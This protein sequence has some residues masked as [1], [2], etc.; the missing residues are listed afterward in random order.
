MTSKTPR[1]IEEKIEMWSKGCN[2]N[3]DFP[4]GLRYCNENDLC[5]VCKN[6]LDL[7][8]AELKGFK[9][10]QKQS[11]DAFKEMIEEAKSKV[12]KGSQTEAVL[13]V[14]EQELLSKIGDNSEVEK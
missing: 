10:G 1:E 3:I 12:P 2:V 9:A 5:K 7:Y 4:K 11:E 8:K 14:L 6:N 13:D